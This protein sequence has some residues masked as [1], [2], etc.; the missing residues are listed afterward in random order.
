MFKC[1]CGESAFL[2]N[3]Y[4]DSFR[5]NTLLFCHDTVMSAQS[6]MPETINRWIGNMIGDTPQKRNDYF[7]PIPALFVIATKFNIDLK[8]D[9]ADGQGRR[10]TLD[11]R[12]SVALT[13]FLK[14][15]FGP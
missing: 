5:I 8:F 10:N 6:A 3:K 1:Y 14:R 9:K 15:D 7:S 2:F 4:S 13:R 11:A 12:W